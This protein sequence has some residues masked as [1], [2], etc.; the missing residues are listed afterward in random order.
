[1]KR[2]LALM[3]SLVL[4]DKGNQNAGSPQNPTPQGQPKK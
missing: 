4:K 2:F 1:M 3:V